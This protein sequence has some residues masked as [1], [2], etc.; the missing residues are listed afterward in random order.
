MSNIL[1]EAQRHNIYELNLYHQNPR[2]GNIQTIAESLEKNGAYKPIVVNRGTHT[3]RPLEVLAG[4]HT[5]KAHRL[6]VEQGKTGWET[7]STWVVDVDEEH[8]TRIVLADNRTADLGT[9]NNDDLLELLGN[10]NDGLEGTGY[11]PGYIDA[12]LGANIPE[13]GLP[14]LDEPTDAD[15]E[16]LK[17][18]RELKKE[19]IKN[20]KEKYTKKIQAP[21]YTPTKDTPPALADIYDTTKTDELIHNIQQSNLDPETQQFLIAA[22]HRHTKIDF[23][24]AAE[25]YAHADA[26]TQQL[27]EEQALVIIDIDNAIRNGYV[28]LSKQLTQ[29]ITEEH[30]QQHGY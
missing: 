30:G 14:S 21:H 17:D 8:A 15:D 4:N 27:M 1:G 13:D 7:I 19:E 3:G 18:P 26:E 22:A 25:Y 6:L 23:Q 5:L 2:V 29:I 11:D 20:L 16:E 28:K 10:L 12:L 9:Y 24:Q